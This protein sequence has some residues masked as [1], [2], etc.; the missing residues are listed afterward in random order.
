MFM[1]HAFTRILQMTTPPSSIQTGGDYVAGNLNVTGDYIQGDK[2]VV[3]VN[4]QPV[5]LPSRGDLLAYLRWVQTS[6]ARW[7]DVADAP[8]P[9]LFQPGDDPRTAPDAY[10]D[11]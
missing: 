10:I 3:T 6:Y 5:E 2:I 9:P 1:N 11:T 8:D 4:G 7:A